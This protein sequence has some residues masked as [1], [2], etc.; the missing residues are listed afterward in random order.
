MTVIDTP[1]GIAFY[2][3]CSLKSALKLEIQGI[4]VRRNFSAYATIKREFGFKGTRL[5]VLHQLEEH[6][7]GIL[8]KRAQ[9]EVE[10]VRAKTVELVRRERQEDFHSDG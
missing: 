1:E 8:M 3:T 2:R 9:E 10:A 7:K 5:A 6:V 4:R